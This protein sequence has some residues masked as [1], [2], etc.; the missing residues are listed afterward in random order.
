MEK[1]YEIS[2]ELKKDISEFLSSYGNYKK[3]LENLENTKKIEYSEEEMND[4]L[5]LIGSFRLR[6][7]F[8]LVE[9]FKIEVVPLKNEPQPTTDNIPNQS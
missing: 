9:R 6:D 8:H 1:K 7:V 3:N 2:N 4:L 5:N